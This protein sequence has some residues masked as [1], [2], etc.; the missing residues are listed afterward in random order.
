MYLYKFNIYLKK[1][2]NLIME[3]IDL[4]EL[5]GMFW[6][7]KIQILLIV[8]IFI[9]IG[10]VYTMGFTTPMYSSSTTLV[11]AMSGITGEGSDN[12]ITTTD[13]TL[14]SKLV[15]T[16]S[17]LVKSKNVL[18]EVISKLSI[19][20]TENDLKK[21]ISVTSIEDT[22]VIK[23]TVSNQNPVYS[24]KIANEIARVFSEKVNEIYNINNIYIVDE[25]EVPDEPSNI[26]HAKDVII[27]AFIG[28][29]LSVAYIFMVNMLDNTIKT[30]EDIEK[31]YKV[32]V[33]VSIPLI[34]SF[35]NEK[36]GKK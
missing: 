17:E 25:A 4:K 13:V 23:I 20:E 26:N 32:P 34:E 8:T 2:M 5:F 11:L 3:E 29:V 31:V 16:Y 22:E 1:G 33:L 21:N 24:A 28:L 12:S 15:P 10:T 27:F 36:G 9:I 30:V 14:N 6:S 19:N 18:R 35:E 7:K